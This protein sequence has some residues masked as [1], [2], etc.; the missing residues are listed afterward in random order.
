MFFLDPPDDESAE[1]DDDALL[2][3]NVEKE[4]PEADIPNMGAVQRY[5]IWLKDRLISEIKSHGLPNCYK[6]GS[7]WI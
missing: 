3:E 1:F 7:F 6:Q 2:N 5:L 4:I